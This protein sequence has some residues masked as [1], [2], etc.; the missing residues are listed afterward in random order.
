QE[1]VERDD[2]RERRQRAQDL[3]RDEAQAHSRS[4][5]VRRRIAHTPRPPITTTAATMIAMSPPLLPPPS[6]LLPVLAP[7]TTGA[8]LAY[9]GDE[10]EN[11]T[12]PVPSG[13]RVQ[14]VKRFLR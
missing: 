14:P 8:S 5:T 9:V 10:F 6:S 4:S 13:C 3:Q 12:G 1:E 11:S 7:A 2:E